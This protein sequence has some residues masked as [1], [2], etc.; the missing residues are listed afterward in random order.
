[1]VRSRPNLS[2]DKLVENQL[3]SGADSVYVVCLKI[4]VEDKEI[5]R[6]RTGT[7]MADA[8]NTWGIRSMRFQWG[9]KGVKKALDQQNSQWA[10]KPHRTIKEGEDDLFFKPGAARR[11]TGIDKINFINRYYDM[12]RMHFF[13]PMGEMA[14]VSLFI[15]L[16]KR[17][18]LFKPACVLLSF[19]FILIACLASAETVTV[20]LHDSEEKQG[21][22]LGLSEDTL[23]LENEGKVVKIPLNQVNTVFDSKTKQP[24]SLNPEG[25]P[26]KRVLVKSPLPR[27]PENRSA[28]P[29]NITIQPLSLL[30]GVKVLE[31]ER[32]ITNTT[33]LAVRLIQTGPPFAGRGRLPL[34]GFGAGLRYRF[35]LSDLQAPRG[36]SIGPNVEYMQDWINDIDPYWNAGLEFG[37]H[38]FL[39]PET[40]WALTLLGDL[41]FESATTPESLDQ[42][43]RIGMSIGF[44]YGF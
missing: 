9:V 14:C 10:I 1:M 39:S 40:P 5:V 42:G 24:F 35:F 29:T 2:A 37:Y 26:E 34:R 27:V 25:D 38:F 12:E 16:I 8:R 4:E 7:T 11:P 36:F 41:L 23:Y 20:I 15:L 17:N 6:R 44:G 13:K 22:L 18:I 33:S 28:V 32:R 43:F 30:A 3:V 19:I 31:V 21:L